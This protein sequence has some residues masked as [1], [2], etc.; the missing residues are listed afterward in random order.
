MAPRTG[1]QIAVAMTERDERD[2][3]RFLRSTADVQL[4]ALDSPS[5][6]SIWLDDFPPRRSRD[7]LSRRFALW[8]KAFAWQPEV[9]RR[10]HDTGLSN[11]LHAPVIEYLRHP[12]SSPAQDVGR[13]YWSRGLPADAGNGGDPE[14]ARWWQQVEDWVKQHAHHR[15]GDGAAVHY[16]PWAWWRYGKWGRG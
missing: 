3:L 6:D 4:L 14:F 9:Q 13:L 11:T 15:T 7:A 2:F 1:K 5:P 12:F 16:L 10:S 8:N